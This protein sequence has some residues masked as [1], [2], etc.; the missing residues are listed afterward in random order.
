MSDD[1]ADVLIPPTQADATVLLV[2]EQTEDATAVL[3]RQAFLAGGFT[4]SGFAVYSLRIALVPWLWNGIGLQYFLP[5]ISPVYREGEHWQSYRTRAAILCDVSFGSLMLVLGAMQ[6]DKPLRRKYKTLHRWCGRAYVVCGAF[7]IGSLQILQEQVGSGSSGGRSE[8]LAWFVDV[9]SILWVLATSVA[10][11]AAI[12]KRFEL[13]RDF[14]GL[15]LALACTPIAQRAYSWVAAAPLAMTA[16]VAT[17]TV[18]SPQAARARW[19]VLWLRWGPPG[20]TLWGDGCLLDTDADRSLWLGDPRA[21]PLLFSLDGYGEGEQL[22]FALS[23]WMGFVTMLLLGLSPFLAH[24]MSNTIGTDQQKQM[25]IGEAKFLHSW[26]S[27]SGAVMRMWSSDDMRLK[28]YL[29]VFAKPFCVLL[30]VVLLSFGGMGGA[31][32]VVVLLIVFTYTFLL[33]PLTIAVLIFSCL[34]ALVSSVGEA[35]TLPHS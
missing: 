17:C 27:G 16:R 25:N 35:V 8:S 9:T 23:A 15:S 19:G 2:A 14:M 12:C 1:E 5:V 32:L 21:R 6:C 29:G 11:V 33:L 3:L 13:H 18:L 10:V 31:I 4:I 22:S 26:R 20:N 28:K 24:M 7:T 34:Y 30:G